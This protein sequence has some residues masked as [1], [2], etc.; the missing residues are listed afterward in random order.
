MLINSKN[1][2]PILTKVLDIALIDYNKSSK[3]SFNEPCLKNKPECYIQS[4][5]CPS[6]HMDELVKN[7]RYTRC[8]FSG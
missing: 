4:F 5:T 8:R 3:S 7:M 6:N 2:R 1:T